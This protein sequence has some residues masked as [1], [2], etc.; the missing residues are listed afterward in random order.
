MKR[1]KHLGHA[2]HQ[3]GTIV[4]DCHEKRVHLIDIS[5]K[6]RVGFGF[7]QLTDQITAVQ[8]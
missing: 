2:L 1:A 7:A 5:V 4:Q 6:I 3:D 8:K